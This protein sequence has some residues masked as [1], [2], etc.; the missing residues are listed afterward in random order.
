MAIYVEAPSLG[1]PENFGDRP[2]VSI[3]L[4]GSIEN[5]TAEDWQTALSKLIDHYFP[6]ESVMILNPRR[7]NWNPDADQKELETQIV[8]EQERIKQANVVCFYFDPKT[9]SPI[10]LLEL[11]Q[12]LG[13]DCPEG[14][15][16][17]VVVYCPEDF[18]RFTNVDVTCAGYGINVHKSYEPFIENIFQTLAHFKEYGC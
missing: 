17:S 4:A 13:R 14:R 16:T 8:W 2:P 1:A 12:C 6:D 11:G 15:L 9:K 7:K 5:G 3:F 18:F 10:S